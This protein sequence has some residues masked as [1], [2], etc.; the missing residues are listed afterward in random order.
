MDRQIS[1]YPAVV[2]IR[3][4]GRAVGERAAAV[5]GAAAVGEPAG[6]ERRHFLEPKIRNSTVHQA[7]LLQIKLKYKV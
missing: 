6:G 7:S 5:E 3:R 2:D 1:T 4:D